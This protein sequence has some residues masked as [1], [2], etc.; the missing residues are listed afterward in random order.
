M[1]NLNLVCS[2]LL[3]YVVHSLKRD[4]KDKIKRIILHTFTL[5]EINEAK[6]SLWE[7]SDASTLGQKIKRKGS[8]AKASVPRSKQD[9]D[10]DDVIEAIEKLAKKDQLNHV[11]VAA[12]DLNRILPLLSE[13]HDR[14]NTFRLE[15]RMEMAEKEID[16][17]RDM[18]TQTVQ[19]MEEFKEMK[20][21]IKHNGQMPKSYAEAA[22]LSL[23]AAS[24]SPYHASSSAGHVPGPVGSAGQVPA[25]AAPVGSK[26]HEMRAVGRPPGHAASSASQQIPRSERPMRR[27]NES[28]AARFQGTRNAHS[29]TRFKGAPSPRRQ[30]FLY[31]VDPDTQCEDIVQHVM[32]LRMNIEIDD[33]KCVSN[34][35]AKFKSF[36]LTCNVKDYYS[37]MDG[38]CW[39]TGTYVRRFREKSKKS[40]HNDQSHDASSEDTNHN[41]QSQSASSDN[42]TVKEIA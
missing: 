2:P 18:R 26:P 13:D 39:P 28:R 15:M 1:A 4:P 27:Q 9:F 3:A 6:E 22:A 10:A 35:K 11:C 12:D 29:N 5:D 30:L 34:A 37:L 41:V 16:E 8:T 17:L 25:A 21:L 24:F 33:V 32:D 40:K 19:M 20:L 14:G 38:N 31:R 36:V 7:K 42:T 23:G